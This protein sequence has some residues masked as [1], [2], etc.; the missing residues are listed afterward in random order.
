MSNTMRSFARFCPLVLALLVT[1]LLFGADPAAACWK[2]GHDA[3][4]STG[5]GKTWYFAEGTTRRGFDEYL[6]VFNPSDRVAILDVDYMLSEGEARRLR[7]ELGPRS[8]TT[9]DVARQV[10]A[11]ADVSM[12]LESSE[13][14]VAERAMYFEYKG[15]WSGA[16]AVAGADRARDQWYFAEGCTRPGFDTYLCLFNPGGREAR[17]DIDYLCGDG[18]SVTRTGVPVAAG[19]RGTVAVHGEDPG[20]GRFDDYRGDVS[21]RVRSTNGVEIVAERPMYFEYRPY[22][23]GGHDVVGAAAPAGSWYFAEGCTRPGFDTYLCLSNPGTRQASVDVEYQCGDG[24]VERRAGIAVKPRS[25]VTI[26][27]HEEPDGTGR[28]DG[29]AGD[30]G[31]KVSSTNGVPVVAERPMYFSYR[32]FWTDGHDAV[33]ADSPELKWYF[34]EGCTRPGY[35]SYLCLQNPAG[36]EAR[37]DIRYYLGNG[38]AIERKDR[39]IPPRSRLTVPLHD[40]V[41]GCGSSD[42]PGGDVSIEVQSANGVPVVAERSVY[43]ASRWRT[44]D[45]KAL[46]AGRGWGEVRQGPARGKVALTFDWEQSPSNALR[47][48]SILRAGRVRAT[49]FLLSMFP[50]GYPGVVTRIAAEGHELASH[51]VSHR[52]FTG[53]SPAEVDN[54]LNRTEAAVNRVT[55]MST[56]PYFRF[57]GGDRNAALI[58]RVNSL[59]YLSVYW[60][61]DPQDW[62]AKTP[63]AVQGAVFS[64]LR[65][66]AIILLHD[67]DVTVAAL[68][69][70]I[71]GLR[72]RGLEPVPLSELLF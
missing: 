55:G 2:G 62:R 9:I 6:C 18:T 30:L 46:A 38:S 42:G 44:M 8:R 58:Q 51:G 31:I 17:V 43:T 66:G 22:L 21:M 52:M 16:H 25:R 28:R 35:E 7:Y 19:S 63:E 13:P 29:P 47:L 49:C 12:L 72:A 68:P 34:A 39:S 33:G 61:V 26:P 1:S 71:D 64:Q 5:A 37:V 45:K 23:N 69:G 54:E 10:P 60:S 24:R 48:L 4:G 14:V 65:D 20:L 40:L 41:E 57:P 36:D 32:P 67:R 15:A 3:M 70:I 56:K 50:E 27:I 53:L 59:G 11:N